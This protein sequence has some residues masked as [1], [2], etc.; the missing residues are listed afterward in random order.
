VAIQQCPRQAQKQTKR[1]D[2]LARG[3]HPA[4]HIVEWK[5]YRRRE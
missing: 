1:F 4:K 5:E 3:D 2:P